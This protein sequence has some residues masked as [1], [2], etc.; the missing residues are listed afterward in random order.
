MY[1]CVTLTT[2]NQSRD[3]AV[4]GAEVRSGWSLIHSEGASVE[5]LDW[6]CKRRL[7]LMYVFHLSNCAAVAHHLQ[8]TKSLQ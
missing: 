8:Q 3:G 6:L 2:E 5:D 7:G 4:T 1:F